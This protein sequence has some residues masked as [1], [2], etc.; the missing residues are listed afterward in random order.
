EEVERRLGVL[1]DCVI[2]ERIGEERDVVGVAHEPERQDRRT[3]AEL[4]FGVLGEL[5][6][7]RARGGR[8]AKARGGDLEERAVAPRELDGTPERED[9][10][11][12]ARGTLVCAC[13]GERAE[14]PRLTASSGGRDGRPA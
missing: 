1:G 11:A 2:P 9:R 10:L 4:V 5:P 14:G 3:S 6:K 8:G 12:R 7:P 13:L